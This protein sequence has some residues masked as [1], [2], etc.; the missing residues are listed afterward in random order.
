MLNE[1]PPKGLVMRIGLLTFHFADNY[2][3][4]MQAYALQKYL[5]S[6]GHD[7]S[8]VDYRPS[9]MTKGGRFRLPRSRRDLYA[10]ATVAFIYLSRLRAALSGRARNTAFQD[11][12]HTHLRI[13]GPLYESFDELLANPP[14]CDAYVCGSD[15]IWNPPPRAG[16]DP[17]YYLAFDDSA[18]KRVAYAASFGRSDIEAEYKKKIGELLNGMDA[19]S[20]RE[21]SGVDLVRQISGRPSVWVPDPALLLD[22]YEEIMADG[23][24]GE[25]VFS[26]SLRTGA[27]IGEVQELVARSCDL[28]VLTP[29]SAQ[30]RWR[31]GG[32]VEHLGPGQWLAAIARARFVVTNSFHGTLFS[33][34]FRK[35]FITTCLVGRNAELNERFHSVL[36]RLGLSDRLLDTADSEKVESLRKAPMDWDGVHERLGK[37]REEAR[38]FLTEALQ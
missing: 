32:R 7:V 13:E 19:I 37:W 16:V 27:L 22:D 25:Y 23:P 3:A 38:L 2:G 1:H 30:Q 29:Y 24:Q 15:Q 35:P 6:L 20:V 34:L 26:Y 28:P 8:F 33:I 5:Q 10:N 14:P 17:A 4:V 18:C 36:S 12:I 9:Y 21:E 31:S 11:F